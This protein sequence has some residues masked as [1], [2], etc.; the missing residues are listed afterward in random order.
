MSSPRLP[1]LASE[2]VRIT[3]VVNRPGYGRGL[4]FS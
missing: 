2:G 4:G 1:S 3:L